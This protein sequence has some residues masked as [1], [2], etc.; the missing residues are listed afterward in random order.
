MQCIL[1]L[2]YKNASE[3]YLWV[4]ISLCWL[5]CR[6]PAKKQIH[7]E[8]ILVEGR[9]AAAGAGPRSPEAAA[10][11]GTPSP[12]D[13]PCGQTRGSGWENQQGWHI[14]CSGSSACP[15]LLS[16]VRGIDPR[17]GESCVPRDVISPGHSISR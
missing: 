13:A 1:Y 10:L 4:S 2:N 16:P 12:A 7:P 5:L 17:D 15:R 14:P 6:D 3:L 11:P 8:G 9:G